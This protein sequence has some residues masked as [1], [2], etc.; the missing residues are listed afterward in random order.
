MITFHPSHRPIVPSPDGSLDP[1]LTPY[2]A[3]PST[4]R[5]HSLETPALLASSQSLGGSETDL[6]LAGENADENPD[7]L[8]AV[9]GKS[10]ATNNY[11]STQSAGVTS[12]QLGAAVMAA[13]MQF[14]DAGSPQR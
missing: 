9:A 10:L 11:P 1:D 12:P 7:D 6:M 14:V 2:Q 5:G 4:G 3:A 13:V 8:I